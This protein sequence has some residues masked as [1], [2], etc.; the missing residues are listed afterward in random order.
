MT[1]KKFL[2]VW[3]LTQQE[4]IVQPYKKEFSMNAKT[5]IAMPV[6]ILTITAC[7]AG[8]GNSLSADEKTLAQFMGE[9]ICL[10]Q[11][12]QASMEGIDQTDPEAM[13]A[14]MAGFQEK[15][16]AIEEKAK[17]LD[18]EN[19]EKMNGITEKIQQDESFR[20]ALFAEVTTAATATC[21]LDADSQMLQ[22]FFSTIEQGSLN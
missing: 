6:L 11:E 21:G 13:Q 5:L 4:T 2:T 18:L 14:A 16:S 7:S 10:G 19:Q 8:G 12:Y 1:N 9:S 3:G 17:S 15:Q 22:E 20:K